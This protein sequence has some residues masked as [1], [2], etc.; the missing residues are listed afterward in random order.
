MDTRGLAAGV[1][2]FAALLLVGCG[3]TESG[4]GSAVGSGGPYAPG[5]SPPAAAPTVAGTAPAGVDPR[6][7]YV[8]DVPGYELASQSV[9]VYGDAGFQSVYVSP[10]GR[11]IHLGVDAGDPGTAACRPN[12]PSG[13]TC[14]ADGDAWYRLASAE[15]TYARAGDGLVVWVWADPKEVDRVTLHTA[16]LAARP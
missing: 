14:V 8:T 6:F 5:A 3:S 12:P 7:V 1:A 13:E 9:G 15:H 4:K 11:Q 2:L 10:Q 16:L